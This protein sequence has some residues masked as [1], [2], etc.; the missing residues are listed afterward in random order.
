MGNLKS[1]KQQIHPILNIS[2]Q[3]DSNKMN[4]SGMDLTEKT[5]KNIVQ[6]VHQS[7]FKATSIEGYSISIKL[8]DQHIELKRN[9]RDIPARIV[10]YSDIKSWNGGN[11]HITLLMTNGK[12]IKFKSVESKFEEN[13]FK[14]CYILADQISAHS[15]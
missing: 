2:E 1:R 7:D 14:V 11:N 9:E 3:F 12:K 4:T 5:I 8:C 15:D 13:L 10:Y 6:N